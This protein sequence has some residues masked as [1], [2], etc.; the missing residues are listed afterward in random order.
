MKRYEQYCPVA[1]SLDVLGERW[2]LLIVRSLL[3]G[4]QR[5]RD[6]R[7]E[8]P[9]IAT[10]LLTARLRTLEEAG[11]VR[12]RQLPKPASVAVYELTDAGQRLGP[13]VLELAGA[14]LSRLGTPGRRE[15]ISAIPLV[16]S[17][18]ASFRPDAAGDAD[19]TYGLELDGEQFT[20]NAHPGWAETVRGPAD[21]PV[22]TI[23]TTARMLAQLLSGATTPKAAAGARNGVQIDGS[24]KTLDR[25][26]AA[27]AY[28]SPA[29][30]PTKTSTRS[31]GR[32]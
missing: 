9:G 19:E 15:N 28:P 11:F 26:L 12:R 21:A 6:L 23:K 10:D 30:G 14:G 25:F 29:T 24:P 17:L 1:R 22:G 8:L 7:E 3:M 20:V 18:R 27:F 13:I 16:L 32:R 31:A 4:P 2:T 5:Y